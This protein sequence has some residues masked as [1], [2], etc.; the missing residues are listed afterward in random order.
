MTRLDPQRTA[1]VVIDLMDRIVG[2]PLAPHSGQEVVAAS[3]A[4]A[5]AFR[6]A[7]AP[8]FLVRVERPGVDE[9]PPGSDLVAGLA[10]DGD[11]VVVKRT[12]GAFHRT[13]LDELLRGQG[14]D[15]LVLCGIAT[16]M[17]VESTAR[18][19]ADHDYELHFAEDAMAALTAEEHSAA[20]AQDLPRF[21]KVA[22]AAGLAA[23]LWN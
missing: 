19:A 14:I 18:A 5:T 8:V 12:V 2:L 7:G 3:S 6:K 15:T 23:A 4:L 9:Q 11:T 10:E 21:G 1:L 17:G 22:T 13:G 20:V 16:N